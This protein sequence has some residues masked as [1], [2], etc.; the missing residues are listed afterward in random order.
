MKCL[1]SPSYTR[2]RGGRPLS[3]VRIADRPLLRRAAGVALREADQLLERLT[4][5]DRVLRLLQ[6]EETANLRHVLR[7]LLVDDSAPIA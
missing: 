2:Q 7:E 1:T 6:A 4:T 5:P 3:V